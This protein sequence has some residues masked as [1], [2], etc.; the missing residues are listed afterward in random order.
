MYTDICN[1]NQSFP[2][3]TLWKLCICCQCHHIPPSTNG[4]ASKYLEATS[5][6]GIL[7]TWHYVCVYAHPV[8]KLTGK[9]GPRHTRWLEQYV[10]KSPKGTER[11]E[12]WVQ[13]RAPGNASMW[14]SWAQAMH[15]SAPRCE[16]WEPGTGK[17]QGRDM[18]PWGDY[19]VIAWGDKQSQRLVW[20]S[21]GYTVMIFQDI[22]SH[23]Q[24]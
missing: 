2:E 7:T 6:Q 4:L 12:R 23:K 21:I 20:L 5:A 22:F 10:L 8:Y 1:T 11:K 15:S 16:V 19:L 3:C 18:E 9:T 14:L 13:I 24:F 17:R